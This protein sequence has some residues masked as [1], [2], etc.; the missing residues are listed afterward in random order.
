M[1]LSCRLPRA[2]AAGVSLLEMVLVIA[3]IAVAGLLAAGVLGGGIEGMRLRS[4]GRQLAAELRFTRTQALASGR[5]QRF[6]LDPQARTWQ[7]AAGHHGRI[8]ASLQVVFT[9]A[10]QAQQRQREGAIVFF[11]DG[12]ATGGRIDLLAGSARWRIDV[13]W[14]TGEVLS[15][16]RREQ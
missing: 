9:G 8:P 2:Y 4:A 3:L 5:E 15:G 14:I 11:P 6:V 12:A 1:P 16:P 7:A 13:G 10:R